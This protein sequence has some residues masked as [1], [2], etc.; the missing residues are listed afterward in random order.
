VSISGVK[1]ELSP[2]ESHNSL[3]V[4]E[5]YHDPL[6]RI[7]RKVRHDFPTIT[8][9][10]AL[11]LANKAMN[12]TVGPEGFVPVGIDSWMP[13]EV[14]HSLE[15]NASAMPKTLFIRIVPYCI[16]LPRST[17]ITKSML[18]PN[19]SQNATCRNMPNLYTPCEQKGNKEN[20]AGSQ[21][22]LLPLL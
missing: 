8:E 22:T 9:H 12:D 10:L 15:K 3:S 13:L 17:A 1:L 6:R 21:Y 5:R 4:G 14:R 19:Q 11:S 2:I 20:Y 16:K 7:C 18:C